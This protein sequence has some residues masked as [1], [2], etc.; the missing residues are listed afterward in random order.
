[1]PWKLW[2]LHR[3]ACTLYFTGKFVIFFKVPLT[4]AKSFKSPHFLHQPPQQV[5]VNGPV[6]SFL[7]DQFILLTCFF[8]FLPKQT[9][10][11]PETNS[12]KNGPGHDRRT[13]LQKSRRNKIITSPYVNTTPVTTS[14]YVNT[15]PSIPIPSLPQQDRCHHR[16]A[17]DI[18]PYDTRSYDATSA[19]YPIYSKS[20]PSHEL[21]SALR[22]PLPGDE[23][24]FRDFDDRKYQ[25]CVPNTNISKVFQNSVHGVEG[26]HHT[27]KHI[28]PKA[29]P[30]K[31]SF[32][33]SCKEKGESQEVWQRRR[34]NTKEIWAPTRLPSC[35]VTPPA[36]KEYKE[37]DLNDNVFEDPVP[38]LVKPTKGAT[39]S[40]NLPLPDICSATSKVRTR[41]LLKSFIC[42]V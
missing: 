22:T 3:K 17:I 18:P 15:T 33:D 26:R 23:P 1:M 38:T 40:E 6:L 34:A 27:S 24:V 16:T 28:K 11:K 35:P 10:I 37:T 8:Y 7:F 19:P 5:F 30:R 13:T 2:H 29:L 25:N 32:K 4:R 42:L 20:C 21:E 9:Y 31:S 39:A 14:H 12:T 41:S 36:Y